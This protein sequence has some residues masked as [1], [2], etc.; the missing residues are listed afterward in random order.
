MN[1]EEKALATPTQAQVVA[2]IKHGVSG[3]FVTLFQ[4][5]EICH[6]NSNHV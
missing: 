5:H 6:Y 2:E 4:T 3:G 1:E